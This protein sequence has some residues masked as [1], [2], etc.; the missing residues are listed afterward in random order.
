MSNGVAEFAA[1]SKKQSTNIERNF[2]QSCIKEGVV[3]SSGMVL[4]AMTTLR[5]INK[6]VV[7]GYKAA[8]ARRKQGKR[9][10]R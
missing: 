8:S 1:L 6:D 10:K 2:V 9:G 4:V 3:D 7:A 5:R